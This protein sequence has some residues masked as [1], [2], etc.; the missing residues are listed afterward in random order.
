MPERMLRLFSYT[1]TIRRGGSAHGN[2]PQIDR[3]GKSK[4]RRSSETNEQDPLIQ[5]SVTSN[6]QVLKYFQIGPCAEGAFRNLQIPQPPSFDLR[7]AKAP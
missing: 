3:R 4:A 7:R 2:I 5:Q 1:S 6:S